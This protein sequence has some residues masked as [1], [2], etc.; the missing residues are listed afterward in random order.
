M[1]RVAR[2]TIATALLV[3]AIAEPVSRQAAAQT[4]LAVDAIVDYRLTKETFARF[5][6]ASGRVG[7]IAREDP[8]FKDAPLFTRDVMLSDD[9]VAAVKVLEARL[10]Q[11]AGL[12]AA[13]AASKMTPREYATFAIALVAARLAHGFLQ[14]GVLRRVPAGTP[15]VNVEFVRAHESDVLRT[16]AELGIRD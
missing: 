9:A 7:E 13:L 12:A 14:T 6:K 16:L 5:V 4:P 8:S 2:I 1:G 11:H 10:A 15:T 3:A